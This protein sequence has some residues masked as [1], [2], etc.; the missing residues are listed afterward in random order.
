MWELAT[1]KRW[2]Q[3]EI[4]NGFGIQSIDNRFV[5]ASARAGY[6]LLDV[7]TAKELRCFGRPDND[8]RSERTCLSPTGKTLVAFTGTELRFFDTTTATLLKI[9]S[10]QEGAP[11]KPSRFA[12]RSHF[13]NQLC[14]RHDSPMEHACRTGWRQGIQARHGK[15]TADIGWGGE[16]RKRGTLAA[17]CPD[18]SRNT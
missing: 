7:K 6:V 9:G 8:S 18:S 17:R 11:A 1:G 12:G 5:V 3:F 10:S 16:G 4:I 15:P 2:R 13:G 14:E